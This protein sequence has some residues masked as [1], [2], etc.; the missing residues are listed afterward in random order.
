[1]EG[2]V[3]GPAAASGE[4]TRAAADPFEKG[5]GTGT[6]KENGMGMDVTK[7]DT[8][9]METITLYHYPR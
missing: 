6:S 7:E 2:T 9:F 4:G 1:M 3:L 5:R 8:H